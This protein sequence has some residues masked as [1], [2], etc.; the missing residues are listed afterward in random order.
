MITVY[1]YDL[2]GNKHK[3]ICNS[4]D[5]EDERYVFRDKRNLIVA[6]FQKDKIT[7]FIVERG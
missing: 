1:L 2:A 4:W 7:G 6:I 5:K 3:I